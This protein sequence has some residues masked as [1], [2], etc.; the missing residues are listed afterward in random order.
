MPLS[1]PG[2][3]LGGEVCIAGENVWAVLAMKQQVW[4][5]AMGREWECGSVGCICVVG[6]G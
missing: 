3:L 6:E 1:P 2:V 5:L 4:S